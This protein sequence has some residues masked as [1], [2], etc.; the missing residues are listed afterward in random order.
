MVKIVT[1]KNRRATD[2]NCIDDVIII[3]SQKDTNN[4]ERCALVG[5]GCADVELMAGKF[6][7]VEFVN[8][9]GKMCII[10][11]SGNL[12]LDGV[13]ETRITTGAKVAA[14]DCQS[15]FVIDAAGDL[16]SW[17]DNENGQLGHGDT[18]DRETPKLIEALKGKHTAEVTTFNECVVCITV[19]NTCFVWGKCNRFGLGSDI[20]TNDGSTKSRYQRLCSTIP[21]KLD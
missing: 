20:R 9:C 3:Q 8:A 21:I 6:G 18:N 4:R 1:F 10:D 14:N 11:Q 13:K 17:G 12:F 2:T 16:W 15:Y 7:E 19:D 5:L